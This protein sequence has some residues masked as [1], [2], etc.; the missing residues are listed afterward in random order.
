M[1]M[2]EILILDALMKRDFTMYAIQKHIKDYYA[3]FTNPSFGAIKPALNRLEEKGCLTCRKMM[4]DGGKLSGY[5]TI[6]S[7]GKNELCRLLLAAPS[8][9][10]LQ[11]F[12]EARIK[13]A[14]A[15]Y[16]SQEE[17]KKMFFLLKSRAMQHKNSAENALNDEYTPLNFYQ[18]I[19]LDNALCEYSNFITIVEGFEKDNARNSQ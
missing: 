10:P 19:I 5:Y 12:S 11:F 1:S 15:G 3:A 4:S 18:K 7:K 14:C 17:R 2:I 16:L 6:T 9:N 13:L 8:E